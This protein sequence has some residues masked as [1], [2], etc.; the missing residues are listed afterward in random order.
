[1]N[2]ENDLNPNIKKSKYIEKKKFVEGK[3]RNKDADD[4]VSYDTI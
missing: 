1:M 3:S 2:D 4:S